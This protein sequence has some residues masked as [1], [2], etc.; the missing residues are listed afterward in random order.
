MTSTNEK[1]EDSQIT[2]ELGSTKSYAAG[3]IDQDPNMKGLNFTVTDVY[4]KGVSK[5]SY[6][7]TQAG[8]I[9]I[10]LNEAFFK[11]TNCE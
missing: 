2:C 4:I 8:V 10:K 1:V 11:P 7:A 6:D 3:T 5:A 9:T